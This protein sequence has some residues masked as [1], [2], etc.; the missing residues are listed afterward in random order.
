MKPVKFQGMNTNYVADDCGDLPALVEKQEDGIG[1]QRKQ[2]KGQQCRTHQKQGG[3]DKQQ[4]IQ[5]SLADHAGIKN[6]LLIV[7]AK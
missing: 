6:R 3:A 1:N 5:H 2:P 4:R 7:V